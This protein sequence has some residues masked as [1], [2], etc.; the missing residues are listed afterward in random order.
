MLNLIE[1]EQFVSFAENKTLLK[2]SELMHISQPTLTRNM[3]HVEEA[4]GVSLFDRETNKIKLNETGW[5]AVEY[6][7]Q[8]LS[9]EKNARQ[10][11]QEFDQKLHSLLVSSCAP[12]P[13]WSFLPKLS[14]RYPENTIISKLLSDADIIAD[15]Q[16]KACDIGI[17]STPYSDDSITSSPYLSEQLFV[18]VPK[19]HILFFKE[20]VSFEELN[21]YNCLL[22]DKIGFWSNL[23]HQKMPASRFLIQTN[24]LDFQELVKSSSLLCFCTNLVSHPEDSLKNRKIIPVLDS[25]A[26]VTY[27]ILQSDFLAKK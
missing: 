14:L 15:F 20:N 26:C 17:I 19:D 12:A 27:H 25:E 5:K 22:Q 21:G 4:F 6:A 7:R 24:D 16:K 3:R 9:Y 18:C 23:C 10:M 11:V 1:L 2:V 13:L 8:L